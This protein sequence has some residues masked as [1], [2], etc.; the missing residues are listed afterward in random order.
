MEKPKTDS[1]WKN[2]QFLGK[3]HSRLSIIVSGIESLI[4][5]FY[6]YFFGT[7]FQV[8]IWPLRNRVTYSENFNFFLINQ[9]YDNLILLSLLLLWI[10]FSIREIKL[11]TILIGL[12]LPIAIIS[13]LQN[14]IIFEIILL[15]SLPSILIIS[16]YDRRFQKK[17]LNNLS[18]ITGN[19]IVLTG[20]G[21]GFLSFITIS[22][23]LFAISPDPFLERNLVY[24]ISL[25]IA[26]ISPIYLIILYFCFPI[27]IITMPIFRT[28][29]IKPINLSLNTTITARSKVFWLCVIL[30]LS[31]TLAFIPH[32]QSVNPNN[33]E[34]SVDTPYYVE[35]ISA[36]TESE[37]QEEF[38]NQAFVIQR[39]GDRPF[40]LITFYSLAQ[41]SPFSLSET[42]EHIGILLAPALVLAT[43]FFTRQLTSNDSTSLL[44][45]FLAAVSFHSLGG[46]YA[47]L[48]ANWF[49][50]VIG[51]LCFTFLLRFLKNPEKK[52]LI[53]FSFLLVAL[54]FSHASTWT[55]F[56]TIMVIFLLA[57]L[58]INNFKR[59]SIAILLL[60]ILV[61]VVV[62]VQRSFWS[63][64]SGGIER[65]LEV[66]SDNEKFGFQNI[67]LTGQNLSFVTTILLAGQISN[68]IIL[69]LCL[70]W[71]F[72]SDI[73]QHYN[74]LII[75]FL[76]VGIIPIIFWKYF[77]STENYL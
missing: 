38:I 34:V 27:K 12:I 77:S 28:L 67:P 20:L 64:A 76:S 48:Y 49:A 22:G 68:F 69:G 62:D 45:S 4:I 29:K 50:V 51:F 2:L 35:W 72:R 66:F 32:F 59:K 63:D 19:Y 16:I 56:A 57:M 18:R 13:F 3:G 65:D 30:L 15:S 8:A 36:L 73:K 37:N 6:I 52:T 61:S 40:S 70:Y 44:A 75:I 1:N 71:L 53:L 74:I 7:F 23:S 25:L 39:Q 10:I 47:G 14:N 60:V 24:E 5:I 9:N 17:I 26:S 41:I 58:K 42:I 55:I 31:I 33:F 21:L 43:Y 11:K 46:I 54:L